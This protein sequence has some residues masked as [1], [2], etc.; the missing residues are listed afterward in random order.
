MSIVSRASQIERDNIDYWGPDFTTFDENEVE[1]HKTLE[2][3]R[4]A[5]VIA[6]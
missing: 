5:D 4:A 1:L 3:S 2:V 6:Q